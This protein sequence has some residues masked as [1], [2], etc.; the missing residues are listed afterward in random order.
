MEQLPESQRP[1]EAET[2]A[3][4][5]SDP[6]D[7]TK[8]S[9]IGR[10][11]ILDSVGI[12]GMG[13]VCAA[14]DPKLNR[15]I[16]LKLLRNASNDEASV[17]GRN[18]LFREAQALAQLSHPNVVTVH[19]VDVF[20]GQVYIAM[21]FV[22]GTTLREWL[23]EEP[24]DWEAVLDK[25]ILAG[26]GLVAAHQADIVHRDFKPSNVLLSTDG[27]VR[28]A[29]FGVAK[30]RDRQ[31]RDPERERAEFERKRRTAS[32]DGEPLEATAEDALIDEIQSNVSVQLTVAGRM[33]G[34][35]AYMAPEQHMGLRIG[36][37]TDQYAF[38]VS[39]YEALYGR[40]P[41]EGADRRDQLAKMTEGKVPPPPKESAG[42]NVPHWLHKILARG[43]HPHPNERWPSMEALLA[44]LER[45]PVKRMRRVAV[46]AVGVL[47]LG[48]GVAGMVLGLGPDEEVNHCP[49]LS[50]DIDE[51][52]N[53]DRLADVQKA[54]LAS[55]KPYAGD[56]ARRVSE[57]LNLWSAVWGDSRVAI[58]E[59]TRIGE[60][61]A[62][63]L[64]VRM[65]CLDQR[66]R[67][68]DAM[69]DLFVEADDEIVERSVQAAYALGD[70]RACETVRDTGEIADR[71]LDQ[72]VAE[73][74]KAMEADL[75]RAFALASAGKA[76]ESLP[77]QAR[78]V[79]R[80]RDLPHP[81]TRSRALYDLSKSQFETGDLAGGEASLR[82]GIELAAELGDVERE[83][84]VWSRLIFYLG[85]E[86]QRFDEGR[87]WSLAASS[88]LVRAGKPAKLEI[89]HEG[90][91]AALELAEGH[92][93]PAVEHYGRALALARKEYGEDHPAT[94]RMMMN[95]AVSVARLRR[96]DD[97]EEVLL[98]AVSRSKEVY[99]A[100]HPW[101]A[102][103]YYNLGNVYL[104][105]DKAD[106]AE[107]S[108]RD[109][110]QIRERVGGPD[111]PNLARPLHALAK[112]A[113][114]NERYDDA[115]ADLERVVAI[116]I[117]TRGE[118]SRDVAA[119][120]LDIAATQ[121]AL[122]RYE[123]ARATYDKV[124]A[125]YDKIFPDGHVHVGGLEKRRCE[126]FIAAELWVAA[127]EAC[128]RALANNARFDIELEI[129]REIQALLVE[130]ERGRGRGL[131]AERAQ[132]RVDALDA[133]IA[134]AASQQDPG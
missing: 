78:V 85:S 81:R 119:A 43:L 74:V 116:Y 46:L 128:D 125:I 4:M 28:V 118:S 6:G 68:F 21:E 33:V 36:P 5:D 11:V 65:Y 8:L 89:R 86:Q 48:A 57:T 19:D 60:Q 29:D 25:F 50:R 27:D 106:K 41:F 132:Q 107:Q 17:A 108:Y 70:P 115:L 13:L 44:A 71:D 22:E 47:G 69:V 77:L 12:G 80:A 73:Q 76:A 59:A 79:A 87:A 40:L 55:S 92:F 113:R 45:D 129:E 67:E 112:I 110:L 56:A 120:L 127:V 42:R 30:E 75:N 63:L 61:S 53:A 121:Q 52:W 58:C 126:L 94:I 104:I 100:A 90:T 95:Y 35:P 39:L 16:A 24:R 38:C 91:I 54:F 18:R 97:A 51:H 62:A 114:K 124:E 15:K 98:E 34:T 26:R 10:Y 66:A 20:E 83:T 122:G 99:G 1:K 111:A 102:T 32:G 101:L 14:Y 131:A 130:A 96:Y 93:E 31:Q 3:D 134:A 105:A 103:V 72:A 88:A 7:T 49:A 109:A 117:R 82:E 64:D 9:T 23:R 84:E 2:V 133:Q 37:F 123:H